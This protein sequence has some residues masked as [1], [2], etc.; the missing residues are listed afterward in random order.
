MDN[1][2]AESSDVMVNSLNFGLPETAQYVTN[3]RLVNYFPS[4]SN[5]YASNAG[6]KQIKFLISGDDN[7]FLDLSSVRLF[8]TLQNTDGDRAKFLRPLAGLHAFMSRYRCTIAG[9]QCQ[10]IIEYARHCEL[11]NCFQSKDVRDMD[12]IES[13]ANPRWDSDYHDYANGLDVFLQ[14]DSV[15]GTAPPHPPS[16]KTNGAGTDADPLGV[17]SVFMNGDHNEWGR[18]DKRYTR[19]SLCGIPGANG[20]ARF[21]HKPCC[22]IVGHGG[23]YYLPLRLGSLELEWTIVSDGNLPVVVPLQ[24]T[25]TPTQ[26]DKEG[27]YFTE[28]NTSVL[29]ELNN[30]L[31]RAEVVSLDNTVANNISSH[32]LSGNSLK[33]YFPMYHTITQTF[34]PNAGEITMNIVKSASKLS[35]A[36][37]TLYRSPRTGELRNRYLP[38]NYVYKRWNYMYS[39]MING[40]INDVGAADTDATQGKGFADHTRQLSWQMQIQS[41][42]YPEF[43]AQSLSET[44]YYLRQAIHYMNPEQESLSFSYRQYRENK[45]I[46]GMSFEKMHANEGVSFTGVNTKMGSLMTFKLK[47]TEGKT[48]G[49]DYNLEGIEELFVHLVSDAILELRSDGGILYD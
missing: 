49:R 22:G 42:K 19:H 25:P 8:A 21:S 14:A 45:F 48:Q 40:E 29:W 32:I 38:D 1:I 23:K 43:E 5:V 33:M 36:F 16:G 35:G 12:D 46:I 27:Y 47:L 9:Q 41:T 20:K 34:D 37:I 13:S 6:N 24:G 31:I 11:F 26:T 28:G 3:R 4:G 44:F 30:L 2:I 39:N 7:S 18:I 15:T 10:D 17:V